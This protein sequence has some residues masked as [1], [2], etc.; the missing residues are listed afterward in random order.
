MPMELRLELMTPIRAYRVDANWELV[1]RVVDEL[2]CV[3]LVVT[4]QDH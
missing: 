3:F 1:D 2:D 4:S